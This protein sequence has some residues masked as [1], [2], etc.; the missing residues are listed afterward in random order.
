MA[1]EPSVGPL[2]ASFA[3]PD[4]ICL[5]YVVLELENVRQIVRQSESV[6]YLE[7][8]DYTLCFLFENQSSIHKLYHKTGHQC[9]KTFLSKIYIF[10]PPGA[11]FFLLY[12]YMKT[13]ILKPGSVRMF[14]GIYICY[15]GLYKILVLR[16]QKELERHLW[17][18][19][20]MIPNF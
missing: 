1:L 3:L 19:F 20:Q 16:A 12:T 8:G 4:Q 17:G 9:R 13:V 10:N 6:L 18:G 2:E 7:I 14:H 15:I 5:T 11:V